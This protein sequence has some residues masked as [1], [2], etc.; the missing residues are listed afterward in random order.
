[1]KQINLFIY[2]GAVISIF[3]F[4]FLLMFQ[5]FGEVTATLEEVKLEQK[6]IKIDLDN[7]LNQQLEQAKDQ[8]GQEKQSS[9]QQYKG[10]ERREIKAF[11]EE[12]INGLL[13][14]NGLQYALT[15]ELNSYPG[16]SHALQL[17]KELNLSKKQVETLTNR[18]SAMSKAKWQQR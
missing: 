10:Y 1:M 17:S 9:T 15:A 12:R 16:A 6:G 11:S 4:I 18:K 13:E 2:F 7:L 5:N 8:V 3:I 14:G